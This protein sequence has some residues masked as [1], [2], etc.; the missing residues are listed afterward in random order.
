MRKKSKAWQRVVLS[1]IIEVYIRSVFLSLP[2]LPP[3][4]DPS[5]TADFAT[6][7]KGSEPF[8]DL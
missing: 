7:I 1:R 8:R 4:E 2:L 5:S 3:F 6:G